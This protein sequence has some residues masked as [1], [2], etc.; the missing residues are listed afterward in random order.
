M[1]KCPECEFETDEKFRRC[2]DCGAILG[3]DKRGEVECS[4]HNTYE[5]GE[6]ME[7]YGVIEKQG[8]ALRRLLSNVQVIVRFDDTGVVLVALA[9]DQVGK[10]V[11]HAER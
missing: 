2:P 10:R 9:S 4:V 5:W 7:V 8:D 1:K 6:V 11:D 3:E